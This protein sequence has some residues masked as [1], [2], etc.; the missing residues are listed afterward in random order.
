MRKLGIVAVLMLGLAVAA[1]ADT[2]AD[3]GG[4][5]AGGKAKAGASC[6]VNADCDQSSRPQRCHENKCELAP[7]VVHPVT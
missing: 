1:W 2:S 5:T 3:K 6:K 7:V 4:K